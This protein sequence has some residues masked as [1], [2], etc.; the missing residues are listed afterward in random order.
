MPTNSGDVA[1]EREKAQA[2]ATLGMAYVVDHLVLAMQAA[3]L[4]WKH[5][6]GAEHAMIW[7]ENTLDGPDQIPDVAET[8]TV[9]QAFFDKAI[10]E[11]RKR[12]AE[13]EAEINAR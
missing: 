7:I 4:E 12:Q 5:G 3:W 6:D 10:A 13:G 8:G 2:R 9:A 1:S 11:S